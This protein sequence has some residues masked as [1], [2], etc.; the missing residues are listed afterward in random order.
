MERKFSKDKFIFIGG[1]ILF[2]STDLDELLDKVESK[3]NLIRR[4]VNRTKK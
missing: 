1:K 2:K 4:V 3:N